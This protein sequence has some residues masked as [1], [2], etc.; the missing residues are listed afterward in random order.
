MAPPRS[1]SAFAQTSNSAPLD[2]ATGE[3]PSPCTVWPSRNYRS[4]SRQRYM[5]GSSSENARKAERAR[6]HWVACYMSGELCAWSRSNYTHPPVVHNML[7]TS[8]LHPYNYILLSSIP[9]SSSSTFRY[10]F[11]LIAPS[12]VTV[13]SDGT[14][15]SK[16]RVTAALTSRRDL[17][18]AVS[19]LLSFTSRREGGLCALAPYGAAF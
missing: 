17:S 2:D 19:H 5:L 3:V 4:G 9:L 18:K 16:S 7:A 6:A 1:T 13:A 8:T 14:R 12:W 15:M 10:A 11:P